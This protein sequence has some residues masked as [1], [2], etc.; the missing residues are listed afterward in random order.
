MFLQLYDSGV[1]FERKCSQTMLDH[2]VLAV[3]YGS[4][5]NKDYWLVKNR[6]MVC[7]T[8][9]IV[10]PFMSSSL[11]YSWGK[12]WGQNGYIMMTRNKNNNCGIATSASF[13]VV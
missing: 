8:I 12:S 10:V 9:V 11:H 2:G 3:G 5:G 4:N 7:M 1:Y 6:Y 13:P